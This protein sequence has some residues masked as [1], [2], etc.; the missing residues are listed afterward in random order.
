M[1]HRFHA[2]ADLTVQRVEHRPGDCWNVNPPA[3][4]RIA[5]LYCRNER[6]II[7][8]RLSEGAP[9]VLV[10]V[11]AILVAGIYLHPFGLLRDDGIRDGLDVGFARGAEM[12]WF[13]HGSTIVLLATAGFE[14]AADIGSGVTIRAGQPLLRRAQGG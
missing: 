6:A 11:A 2:P 5:S 9:L 1:Y 7:S 8:A 4:A 14:L 12:G 3:L 13:E 10:P